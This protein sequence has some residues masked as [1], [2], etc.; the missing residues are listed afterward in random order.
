[1]GNKQFWKDYSFIM[2]SKQRKIIMALM[3]TPKT[4][5]EIKK[6]A[7]LSLSETSR[8]LRKFTDEGLAKCLNPEDHLGRVYQLTE[9]GKKIKEKLKEQD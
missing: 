4:V 7:H 3:E 5:T 9:R 6:Q 2:R 1:M 8:V